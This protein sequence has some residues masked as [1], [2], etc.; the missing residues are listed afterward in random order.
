M[1]EV[2]YVCVYPSTVKFQTPIQLKAAGQSKHR[3]PIRADNHQ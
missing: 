1:K 3:V 2:Q